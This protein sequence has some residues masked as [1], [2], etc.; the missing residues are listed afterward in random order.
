MPGLTSL[1]IKTGG[2]L[3]TLREATFEFT[4]YNKKQLDI[5]SALYMRLGFSVLIEWGHIPYINNEGQ[6][7]T[8]PKPLPFFKS[9]NQAGINGKEELMEMIQENRVLH[10]G[11]YDALW[12][13]I[14]NF[15]YSLEDNGTFKCQIQ[16]VGAGD[17]LESLKI[18]QPG[19][20][21]SS[22]SP[23]TTNSDFSKSPYPV[24]SE[25]NSSFLNE[26]LFKIFTSKDNE[27][28]DIVSTNF[29]YNSDISTSYKKILKSYYTS[30][31]FKYKI[32]I[33]NFD[34][35]DT[36]VKKGF[37]FSLISKL[38]S[39]QGNG[40]NN[41]NIP[42]IDFEKLFRRLIVGYEI[43]GTDLSG[44]WFSAKR[45]ESDGLEQVYITLGH[46]LYMIQ[47]LGLIHDKKDDLISPY[48]LI[49]INPETNRCYTF[50]GHCSLDPTVCLIGS[51]ELPY[52]IKSDFF[53]VL[54]FRFPF[55]D[56][57]NP[58]LGGRFMYTLLNLNFITSTLKKYSGSNKEND[59][60]LIDF[61]KDILDGVSKAC[62]GFNEF[63][64]VPDDDTRCIRI[65][66]DRVSSTYNY[67]TDKYL[68]IPVLGKESIV[69][70][71]SYSSKISPQMASQIVIAAQAKDEI[72]NN[73]DALSFS[74]LNEGL[75]NR[76]SP[77]R[78]E[79]V[80]EIN[81]ENENDETESKYI[82]LRDFIKDLYLGT[83]GAKTS[84][85]IQRETTIIRGLQGAG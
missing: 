83:G 67:E 79:S 7:E 76:L 77:S 4:C 34:Q 82:E 6:L 16:L 18:N 73:K 40:S 29:T 19:N 11:N 36:I 8:K 48:A 49:D 55:Y 66:D 20:L 62:G 21:P 12:G 37:H 72:K 63:R 35:S 30:N 31:K 58:E 3:G 27:G 74:H 32:N 39:P 17:I 42:D 24:V 2:K 1:S 53:K 84:S 22:K 60:Y 85:E 78:V 28:Q 46:L 81:K 10:S 61:L 33:D 56:L 71:F 59:V 65:F 75:T 23:N 54:K 25:A 43:N 13:T 47:T 15:T 70:G 50:S 64:I 57:S 51:Q 69:Y 52:N 44:G 80:T 9:S 14:K 26:L 38:N 41:V 45:I 68:T 5:M